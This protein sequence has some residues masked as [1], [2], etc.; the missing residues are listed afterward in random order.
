MFIDV[1]F[2]FKSPWFTTKIYHY[3]SKKQIIFAGLLIAL[4]AAVYVNWYYT[5]PMSEVKDGVQK[6]TTEAQN[7]GEAQYVNA[8]E[9]GD[10]FESAKLNRSKAHA[11]AQDALNKVI[12]SDSADEE[13]KAQARE[14]LNALAQSIQNE[15]DIENL[16]TA[17]TGGKVLV[18]IGD[19][20]EVILEKGTL[21]D[22]TAL[23]IKEI[24]VNKTQISAEK[25]TLVEAK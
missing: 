14:K 20:V 23:Q 3:F 16:I 17:K 15:A 22:T 7:L 5:K 21:N 24:V 2:H 11:D 4:C 12:E 25:I 13:S 6:E 1:K 9:A 19:T 10:Y 18:S 8:T